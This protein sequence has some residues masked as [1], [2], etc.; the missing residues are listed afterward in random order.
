M[1]PKIKFKLT[2]QVQKSIV[3]AAKQLPALVRQNADGRPQY[4]KLATYK[5]ASS[6]SHYTKG[7]TNHS[8][9]YLVPVLVNHE[10]KMIE[11]Y[12]LHG[13][14]ALQRYIEMVHEINNASAQKA[15][16]EK[17]TGLTKEEAIEALQQGKKV[18]HKSFTD[19]EFIYM[20]DGDLCD[21][22][23]LILDYFEFWK[24]RSTEPFLTDWSIIE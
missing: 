4:R 15:T 11:T 8:D 7:Y 21:E 22:T 1:K 17:T 3:E 14:A 12:Q 19:N 10:V 13:E 9:I 23:G 6:F 2:P 5:G 16:P 18:I 20:K 24:D